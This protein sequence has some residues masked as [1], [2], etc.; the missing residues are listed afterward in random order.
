ME[1]RHDKS[2]EHYIGIRAIA[3]ASAALGRF[4]QYPFII[5]VIM[6][7]ARSAYFD[8]WRWP[9]PL[10]VVIGANFA[11]VFIGTLLMRQ[12]AEKVRQKAIQDLYP[13]LSQAMGPS[14]V[15]S[16]SPTG[17]EPVIK[18]GAAHGKARNVQSGG[19]PAD[20]IGLLIKEIQ[21]LEEGAFAPLSRQPIF[22]AI[23]MPFGGAG[24][25]ALL[26]YLAYVY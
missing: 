14:V 18:A 23:L 4:V 5:L 22:Q 10:T 11:V 16:S 24:V 7:L 17:P 3:D 19:R 2:L 25:L 20:Q 8:R 21:S 9:L 12:A 6:I 1:Q 13:H 15:P 26:N